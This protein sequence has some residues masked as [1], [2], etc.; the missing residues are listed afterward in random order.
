MIKIL[1]AEDEALERKFLLKILTDALGSA[2]ELRDVE[3]GLQAVELARL[4]R[5]DLLLLD[6]RMPGMTGLEAAE[7]IRTFLPYVR[8]AL[9]TA[10]GEFSYAQQAIRL[11]VSDYILKPVEDAMLIST[12]MRLMEPIRQEQKLADYFTVPPLSAKAPQGSES[13]Q[14]VMERVDSYLRHNYAL[15]IS[16]ER[17]ADIIGASPG[18]FSK[19]F[20]QHFGQTF[21]ERL[22]QIRIQQAKKLLR[23]TDKSTREIGEAVGYPSITYFN[24]KFKK[25]TGLPPAEYRRNPPEE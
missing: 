5:P 2:A 19:L 25:E 24:A 7:K 22:T 4:W 21:L 13:Q 10:Y 14:T 20:K 16:L 15:D 11:H 9:I 23:T 8:I 17:V 12:V 1:I 3:N 18:Y 6:I